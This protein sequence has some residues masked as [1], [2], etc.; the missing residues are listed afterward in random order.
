MKKATT[1]KAASLSK[2]TRAGRAR[3]K[4]VIGMTMSLDGF[5]NDRKGQVE[6]LYPDLATLRKTKALRDA[7]KNTGAVVMGRGAYQMGKG[8]FTGYE[9]QVP[10]F[11]V[12]H[13]APREPAK[14]EN[15][16][17]KFTYV[18]DGLVSAVEQAKAAAD[19][20]DVV[21]VGGADITQ[22][23]LDAGLFDELQISIA[24]ILL[25]R[26]LRLF[27]HMKTEIELEKTD[28]S[29]LMGMTNLTFRRAQK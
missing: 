1:A 22:Q 21:V 11:V 2:S 6:K 13:R 29:T 5:V 17:L 9:F 3:G 18:T 15:D 4:V 19:G 25:G 24:P 23:L 8:D 26:G 12:T 7:I 16:K 10:I 20:K 28:E 27:E 14:G